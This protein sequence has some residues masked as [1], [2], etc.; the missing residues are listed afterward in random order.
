[1]KRRTLLFVCILALIKLFTISSFAMTDEEMDIYN[2][3]YYPR[4]VNNAGIN[5]TM[6]NN[7]AASVDPAT[8]GV[9]IT[10]T[11]IS[12]PGRNGFDL[13]IT[14]TYN[15]MQSNLYEPYIG[16]IEGTSTVYYYMVICEKDY[17]LKNVYDEVV[18]TAYGVEVG[19]NPKY[20]NYSTDNK[21][22]K[23]MSAFEYD[24]ED[25][26]ISDLFTSQSAAATLVNKLNNTSPDIY[27]VYPN[28]AVG[29]YTA[30]YSNFS[31]IRI[32]VEVYDPDY[33]TRLMLDTSTERY[34]K[35]GAGWI[36]DFPY[37][38]KRYGDEWYE[39]LHYGSKGTW[40]IHTGSSG[41]NNG[42]VGYTLNDLI[43]DYDDSVYHDG[44]ESEYCV[45]EKNGKKS[46]FGDD[47]RLLLMRD[48]FGN[49]IKFYHDYEYYND[50]HGTRRKYPYL[51][52]ITDSVGRTVNVSYGAQYT[53]SSYTYKNITLTITDPTNTANNMS[54]VYRLRLL[55]SSITG[56][57]D[58]EEY[59]LDRVTR[60][61]GEY[62][63]YSYSFLAAPVSFF[64]RN[65]EFAAA[66]CDDKNYGA[67][68][69][70]IMSDNVSGVSGVEN[71][72][73]LLLTAKNY[74]K[75]KF[76][77]SYSRFL[78]NCTP[79]GSMLFYKAFY[80]RD[81][82][83]TKNGVQTDINE[84]NYKYFTQND[85]E[86]DGFPLYAVDTR[87]P[88]SFRISVQDIFGDIGGTVTNPVTNTH[89]YRYAEIE[90][91]KT[92]ILDNSL[93]S[94]PDLKTTVN[95]TY[96]DTT[97]LLTN[98]L[99]KQYDTPTA[100]EY[101]QL[102]EA[103]VYDTSG[104]GD[105]ISMT[106]NSDNDRTIS[107]TYNSVYHY[108]TQKTYK[109]D[110]TTTII[111]QYIPSSDNKT[112]QSEKVYEN[113]AL[114]KTIDYTYDSYGNVTQTKEYT[115]A[116]NEYIQTDYSYTDTQYNGQ[117]TGSNLMSKT[118][119]G[120]SNNDGGSSNIA[121]TYTYDWRGN[122]LSVTDGKGNATQYEYDVA[123]R[124]TKETY[125]DGSYITFEYIP[126]TSIIE[127]VKTDELGNEF[128]YVYDSS[129]NLESEYKDTNTLLKEYTYDDRNNLMQEIVYSSSNNGSTTNYTYDT[130]QRPVSK[131]VYDSNNV[132]VHKETYAYD[133][134]ADYTKEAV[135]VW[136][137][138][139]N[140]SVVTSVYYDIYGNKIKTE[141]ADSQETYTYDYA[142]NVTSVKSA[143]ANA[144][145]WSETHTTEY[146]FMGNVIKETDELG[147][148]TQAEY[149]ALGRMTK[150]IDQNNYATEYKY[151][152][153]GRV[154][155]QKTPFEEAGGTV[156]YS[157]KKLWYDN[158]GNVIKE[159]VQT[160]A[161]GETESFSEV[162]YT[163]DNRDRLTMTE[164]K[165]GEA[166]NDVQYDYDAKGNLLRTYT[167][168]S[169]P[170]TISGLDDVT[171]T[172]MDFA[173]TKYT[174]DNW[175]RLVSTTDALGVSETNT[176]DNV[177]GLLLSSTDRKGQTFN[178]TYDGA[179]KLLS[180]TLAD[181][182]NAESTTYG[183]TGVPLTKQNSA[184]TISYTYNAKGQLAT[185]SDS[186]TGVAKTYTYDA[187]GNR[188]SMTVT[189][190]GTTEISQS[191]VYDKLNRLVSVSEGGNVIATYTYDNK[192]NR[193][194]TAAGGETTTYAYNLANMLTSQVTGNKLSESYTYYLNGN[195]KSKTSNGQTTNYTYDGMNRLKSENNVQYSFDDFGNRAAMTG[196]G[197]A[198]TYTYD[199]NNRLIQS[200][201]VAGDTTTTENYSYD[202]N[203]N[204]ISKSI[205]IIK[206][207]GEARSYSMGE[208]TNGHIAFY[209]YDCYNRLVEV[210]TNGVASTY[211]YA[212]DGLRLSKTVDGVTTTFVYDDAN[213]IEEVT[214]T[215]TKKY[216]RGIEIVKNDDN[217]YY[218][219][220]GQG[221][222]AI[223]TNAEDIVASYTF[224]AYGNQLE[225]NAIYNPFG[226]R[227]EYQDLCSGLIY[228]RNRYYDPSIGRFISEDP[229]HD[230]LNW[231]VYCDNN[232]VNFIDPTGYAKEGD[233]RFSQSVRDEISIYGQMWADADVAYS[234]GIISIYEKSSVQ[235]YA[236]RMA[237]D[238]R[239]QADHPVKSF[240]SGAVE[241]A[242]FEVVLGDLSGGTVY[243]ADLSGPALE[244][245]Y[246]N[247][248]NLN[249]IIN[250]SPMVAVAAVN[251]SS[252][253]R[254]LVN[255]KIN[256]K[257]TRVD[258]EYPQGGKPA[259]LHVQIKGT[260]Q[261]VMIESLDDLDKLPKAVGKNKAIVNTVKKGLKLLGKLF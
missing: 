124:V 8:G 118:V 49:E 112:I 182:T 59:V 86:Y 228:L 222:V 251:S 34:S 185:E 100:T 10:A 31:I 45:T 184:S 43:I 151:D 81:D 254:T 121:E 120:V 56:N 1:M 96:D 80:M 214:P 159:R 170:L 68:N 15:S 64:D 191:Y 171:G 26:A 248:T 229:V 47:G 24:P 108:P 175:S 230:G 125:P 33:D 245:M 172:D 173:V 197:K 137:G 169:S 195:Q 206:P 30:D 70:Y 148:I 188:I 141:S 219:Y 129:G 176:Y 97:N 167:G 102:N 61:D 190:N 12:L 205:A 143:N 7:T 234:L 123:N 54:F 242:V 130:V 217:L 247:Q 142:G 2:H 223:L 44:E 89:T 53:S 149:D 226:Y 76:N 106:P 260:G 29:S 111:E 237:D 104:Y 37:I 186:T 161:P 101:M 252:K 200:I 99:T 166:S 211:T 48:R 91:T 208:A 110:S 133:V 174:Y 32:A 65:D 79:T 36:F 105:L 162:C 156:Y 250:T 194:S 119:S 46:Y 71:K 35:L 83:R 132:L 117:F 238:I 52:G 202:P 207:E 240:F 220:S 77:F 203:G 88:S 261:K 155:E 74:D 131:E 23:N 13:N 164:T 109:Q 204:Q 78:K 138:D 3:Q 113:D 14:R 140:P 107:Y 67:G 241:F 27:A 11:D 231:Y 232:P 198:T 216:Y 181:G 41:G 227:G 69:S 20:D 209:D 28:A 243:A 66:N 126:Y 180:K 40:E 19:I 87:I 127:V 246:G 147:G 92:I 152:A 94:S 165:D 82:H 192:G 196:D 16:E 98:K 17:Q 21:K 114:K 255:T 218:I 42:L 193:T 145:N 72:Y 122:V 150:A 58:A 5:R 212:P 158:N 50:T 163:Y 157:V 224:D 128:N 93:S 115:G 144:N 116:Q 22:Y 95:Y 160:N 153:L 236:E 90:D 4:S 75:T 39:Y 168:L 178:Y 225:E 253:G 221:D 146:D 139:G 136:G 51:T 85:V 215:D 187:N 55:N 103:Y 189:K 179:G 239:Y 154:I 183:L 256:G 244:K 201:E 135:T 233:E 84:H 134:T 62:M 259:N 73:A 210:D 258:I 213:I 18:D 25:Y 199:L 257:M 235:S 60:D 57:S 63:T 177:R 9:T 38:E 249:A 6:E